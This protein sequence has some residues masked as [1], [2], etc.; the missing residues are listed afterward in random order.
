MLAANSLSHT[1]TFD[2]CTREM[3]AR[4]LHDANERFFPVTAAI[5]YSV[6]AVTRVILHSRYAKFINTLDDNKHTT[7]VLSHW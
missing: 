3:M 2:L 7:Y 6:T 5:C 1:V 4:A